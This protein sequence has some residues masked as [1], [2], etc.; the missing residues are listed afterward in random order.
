VRA[1]Q[2]GHV[3]NLVWSLFGGAITLMLRG[4]SKLTFEWQAE[5]RALGRE[6]ALAS[7]EQYVDPGWN[8]M[9]LIWFREYKE[10]YA[11]ASSGAQAW[12]A[13]GGLLNFVQI[14]TLFAEAC[15]GMGQV[16]QAQSWARA[17]IELA[18]RTGHRWYEAEAHRVLGDVLLALSDLGAAEIAFLRAIEIAKEQKTKSWELRAATSLARLWRDQGKRDEARELLAPVYGRFTEGFDTLDLKEAKA[19]LDE[20]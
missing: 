20:V 11:R 3:F 7:V 6:H 2:L 8:G 15:L 9:A 16:E 18:D 5:G 12:G 17:A 4:N 19:L 14:R 13:A 10:G 1:R